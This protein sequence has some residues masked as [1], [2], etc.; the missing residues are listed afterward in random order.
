[1]PVTLLSLSLSLRLNAAQAK[2]AKDPEVSSVAELT[3]GQLI[4]GYISSVG[5]RGIFI[6]FIQH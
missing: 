3:E 2:P 5:D 6:R 4:R 1:M